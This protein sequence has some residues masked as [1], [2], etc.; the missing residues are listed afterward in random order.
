MS[1]I[2]L[3]LLA[4]CGSPPEDPYAAAGSNRVRRTAEAEQ[5]TREAADLIAKVV[6]PGGSAADRGWSDAVA[7]DPMTAE[8]LEP[9]RT[10]LEKL[11]RAHSS[12]EL[13]SFALWA[14][15]KQR[16]TPAHI[17]FA[18]EIVRACV[19][20]DANVLHQ[21]L[22]ALE[23]FGVDLERTS[24]AIDDVEANRLTARRFLRST[25]S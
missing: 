24:A 20:R 8:D 6:S 7:Q 13:R 3:G 12:A 18:T 15:G 10:S 4:A 22:I 16:G 5:I 11:V 2:L 1:L 14:W 9:L 21:A 23:N 19:D 17:A 25:A